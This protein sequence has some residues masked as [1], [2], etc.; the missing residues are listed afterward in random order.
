[1]CVVT[2]APRVQS[3]RAAEGEGKR[4]ANS[5]QRGGEE[6]RREQ[7]GRKHEARGNSMLDDRAIR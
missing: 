4:R 3:V 2:C 6:S 5:G 7:E 1:M